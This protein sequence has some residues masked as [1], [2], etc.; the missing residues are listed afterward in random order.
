MPE[1]T[2]CDLCGANQAKPYPNCAHR[3]DIVQ[4]VNCGLIY[5][6]GRPSLQEY[7]EHG[8]RDPLVF[9]EQAFLGVRE[10]PRHRAVLRAIKPFFKE[11]ARLL[12]VGAG[13]GHM[14]N[15]AR[16]HGWQV[17]GV[18][19]QPSLVSY[20]RDH[21]DL[22]LACG[23]LIDVKYPSDTFDVI[24][25][26]Q[27]LEHV[28]SPTE[29]LMEA[30]RILKPSGVLFL[31]VPNVDSE[32]AR[33]LPSWW[34]EYHFYHFSAATLQSYLLKQHFLTERLCINPHIPTAFSKMRPIAWRWYHIATPI[35]SLGTRLRFHRLLK[36]TAGSITVYARKGKNL[37]SFSC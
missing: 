33:R 21:Y 10:R 32:N 15:L 29:L 5:T 31:K 25:V 30:H 19:L 26:L 17:S 23:Q 36:R 20:A 9:R 27:V 7:L 18:E 2:C 1:V 8:A 4:C 11:G 3:V 16:Q 34:Q 12:D 6:N 28:L 13:A 22:E 37:R 24:V 35:F 14:L